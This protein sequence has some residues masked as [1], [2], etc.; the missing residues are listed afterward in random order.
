VV[1]RRKELL[2]GFCHTNKKSFKKKATQGWRS[3]FLARPTGG[4]RLPFLCSDFNTFHDDDE[5]RF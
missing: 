2:N 4:D 1:R 3:L 5:K